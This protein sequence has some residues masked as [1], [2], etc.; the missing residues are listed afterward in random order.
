MKEPRSP[1]RALIVGMLAVVG[2]VVCFAISFSILKWPGTP[3]SV[4]A[5]WRLI[6][7]AVLWWMLLVGRR[8]RTGAALPDA[9]T[10]RL[11]VPAALCFGVNVSL[12]FLGITKT[13]VAH[14]EFINAMAPIVLIPAGMVMF[15][16]HPNWKA[17]RW[18]VVSLVGLVIVLTNGPSRGVASVEGDVLVALSVIAF[19]AYQLLARRAR[20]RG[21]SPWDF[22]TVAMTAAVV[23]ATPVALVSAGDEIWPLSIEA[24]AAVAMLSVLTGMVGHGMLYYAQHHVPISTISIIQAG[25]PSL[26]AMFA[27][28]LLGEAL[29]AAQLP[30]MML[31]TL[32]LVLVFS[33]SLRPTP[34]APVDE[35]PTQDLRAP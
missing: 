32:G 21:V 9:R 1:R 13:S 6:G 19:C 35:R 3:G 8:L 29:V 7:S 17:L 2:S 11:T 18:S 10:W 30:G 12:L 4:I 33:F 5:W 20:V 16:E 24:W 34:T 27:W 25:Q 28:V 22:M 26:S 31:V 15:G 14:G 23:T